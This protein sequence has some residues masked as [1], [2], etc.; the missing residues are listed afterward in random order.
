MVETAVWKAQIKLV[1][2]ELEDFRRNLVQKYSDK[3]KNYLP[4]TSSSGERIDKP[5]DVEIGQLFYIA[6]KGKFLNKNEFKFL[7]TILIKLIVCT[8][9]TERKMQQPEGF[10]YY[11]Y[12]FVNL[13]SAQEFSDA[14]I[15]ELKVEK[16]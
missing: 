7:L 15:I 16:R 12:F 3:I 11:Q 5:S 4:I 14:H 8:F 10:M 6:G 2:P 13:S 1:F 9:E